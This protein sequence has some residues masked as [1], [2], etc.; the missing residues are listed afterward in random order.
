MVGENKEAKSERQQC[1]AV[2]VKPMC[3]SQLL[4]SFEMAKNL[5]GIVREQ[6]SQNEI[7]PLWIVMVSV[8]GQCF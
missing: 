7:F 4:N 2:E 1:T 3:K 6:L 8:A 5:E